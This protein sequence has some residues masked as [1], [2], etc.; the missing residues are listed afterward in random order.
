MKPRKE[1]W[2]FFVIEAISNLLVSQEGIEKVA[3]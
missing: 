2:I 3:Y 1:D